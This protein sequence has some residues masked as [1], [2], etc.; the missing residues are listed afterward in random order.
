MR[1]RNRHGQ[2]VDAVP[3]LVVT[4]MAL[5]FLVSFG[6]LYGTIFGLS[7]EAGVGA[8]L[9]VFVGCGCGA[10]YRLVWTVDPEV[11]TEIPAHVRFRNLGYA[12]LAF[13]LLLVL[14]LIPVLYQMHS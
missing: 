3:F 1:L 2:S 9:V 6:P 5:M 4:G 13:F 10:Y 12:A 8:S 11:R 7:I 14:L